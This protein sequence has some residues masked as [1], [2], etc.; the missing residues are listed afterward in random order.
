[1]RAVLAKLAPGNLES[2]ARDRSAVV[3]E[4]RAW[5]LPGGDLAGT[6][7]RVKQRP[8]R[9]G[10]PGGRSLPGRNG[11]SSSAV[12][13]RSRDRIVGSQAV[14]CALASVLPSKQRPVSVPRTGPV[15]KFMT[16]VT[17]AA[18]LDM[19]GIADS[20]TMRVFISD[21]GCRQFAVIPV[22]ARSP[23][24][25]K[26][27]A[28]RANFAALHPRSHRGSQNFSCAVLEP[29]THDTAARK[30]LDW[31][32]QKINRSPRAMIC[33]SLIT[34]WHPYLSSP[35]FVRARP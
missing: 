30:R 12:T 18:T 24:K 2:E 13:A 7:G 22:P 20:L 26:V 32:F 27:N 9:T 17:S 29:D 8:A 19:R 10:L 3:P 16:A 5:P 33:N 15:A 21:A 34:S 6:S 25:S 28:A 14:S 11:A 1:M 4:P 35:A 31:P 23:A